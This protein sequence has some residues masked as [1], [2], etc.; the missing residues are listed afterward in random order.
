MIEL[1]GLSGRFALMSVQVSPPSLVL[2]T[3]PGRL[4]VA[5]LNPAYAAYAMR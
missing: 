3:W 2:K 5:A 1:T 4:G